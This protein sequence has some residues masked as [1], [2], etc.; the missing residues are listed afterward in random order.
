MNQEIKIK[1][2]VLNRTHTEYMWMPRIRFNN[3]SINLLNYQRRE[4]EDLLGNI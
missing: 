2:N 4:W 3:S 1:K